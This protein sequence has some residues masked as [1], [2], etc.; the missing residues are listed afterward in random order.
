MHW[1]YKSLLQATLSIMPF[2]EHINHKLQKMRG[3]NKPAAVDGAVSR[4]IHMV[5]LLAENG[6]PSLKGLKL[7]EVGTGWLPTLPIMFSLLGADKIH[8]YDHVR[9]LRLN[10]VKMTLLQVIKN[11]SKISEDIGIP[12]NELKERSEKIILDGDMDT[13]LNSMN[14]E[15][16][17]PG[18][19]S[20][21]NLSDD[22][23]DLFFSHAVLEHVPERVVLNITREAF[24]TLKP[25]GLFYNLIGLHDH[26]VSFDKRISKVNF[27]R[28]PESIWRLLAKNKITYLN[29][30]RNSQ[31]IETIR[32]CGFN[33]VYINAPVDEPSLKV[34]K[35][36]KIN[37]KFKRFKLEDLAV[38]RSEIIAHK[39]PKL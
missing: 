32:N 30:L 14:I 22:S 2:G 28:Y 3:S 4:G 16:I 18:D 35:K 23:I 5:K 1:L 31:F 29:R 15:Y 20:H 6:L 10:L 37:K 7:I 34:L 26:Y 11:F 13:L 38:I 17:A 25:S 39:K 21:T 33:I 24:R 36:M 19:A 9:H 12:T 8:T 27:L